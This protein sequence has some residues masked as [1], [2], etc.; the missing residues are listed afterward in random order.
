MHEVALLVALETAPDTMSRPAGTHR[1]DSGDSLNVAGIHILQ[2]V[3]DVKISPEFQLVSDT[4][5][6]KRQT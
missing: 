6:K 3:E 5:E 1:N 4:P 2:G